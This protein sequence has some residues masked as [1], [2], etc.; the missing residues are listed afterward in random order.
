MVSNYAKIVKI[1]D[2]ITRDNYGH[3]YID[4]Q[5]HVIDLKANIAV[6]Y[7]K[8]NIDKN[9]IFKLIFDVDWDCWHHFNNNFRRYCKI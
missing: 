4:I 1:I 3:Y 8:K 5:D 2:D 9:P 6:Y 7:D